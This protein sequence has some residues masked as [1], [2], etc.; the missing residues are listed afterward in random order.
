[1]NEWKWSKNNSL[2]FWSWPIRHESSSLSLL[3]LC[4]PFQP[5]E[6][7]WETILSRTIWGYNFWDI[8]VARTNWGYNLWVTIFART[9]WPSFARNHM[10]TETPT[11]DFCLSKKISS[12]PEISVTAAGGHVVAQPLGLQLPLLLLGDRH[13]VD[14]GNLLHNLQR[15]FIG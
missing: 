5:E 4:V 14:L 9:N 8:I 7:L 12:K 6:D 3:S 1:M 13:V 2:Y 10:W 11:F 15:F